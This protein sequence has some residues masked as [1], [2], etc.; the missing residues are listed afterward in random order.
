M[1]RW[2]ENFVLL[3]M[4]VCGIYIFTC[5]TFITLK[6]EK[7]RKI[8]QTRICNGRLGISAINTLDNEE[9]GCRFEGQR[10]KHGSTHSLLC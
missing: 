6:V 1:G 4:P 5:R 10:K 7:A 8:L 9:N 3:R 2:M